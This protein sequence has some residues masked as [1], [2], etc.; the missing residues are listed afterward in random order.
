MGG[1]GLD[2]YQLL[3][4]AVA[5]PIA[6][7]ALQFDVSYSSANGD[8][9]GSNENVVCKKVSGFGALEAFND[10]DTPGGCVR[11]GQ[12]TIPENTLSL[13]FAD[14]SGF[15]PPRDLASCVFQKAAGSAAPVTTDF[16]VTVTDA[17]NLSGSPVTAAVIISTI[18]PCACGD[19]VVNCVEETCDVGA[20]S[21]TN[22]C[23]DGTVNCSQ[24]TTEECD[25]G[26][27]TSGDGCSSACVC[28]NTCG[29][30]I[31]EAPCEEC[32]PGYECQF[33]TEPAGTKCTPPDAPECTGGG[34]CLD[35]D[36][37]NCAADCTLIP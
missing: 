9:K 14:S 18:T 12:P 22:T 5:P 28:E 23:G 11:P 33:G 35:V 24:C 1:G 13:G 19:G 15:T 25:D 31:L 7:G 36:G 30:G 10:C 26:N 17:S 8:F 16:T 34:F 6:L 4:R 29:D 37:D 3:F 21:L 27:T 20:A 2:S 32:D